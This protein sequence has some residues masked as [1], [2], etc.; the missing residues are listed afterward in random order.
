MKSEPK[1]IGE[2][3]SVKNFEKFQHYK[4]RSP[5]WIK[6]YN[7]LLDNYEFARLPDA[8]KA[9]LIAIW[10]LASRY[11]N[12]IPLDLGWLTKRINTTTHLNLPI[13]EEHGFIIIEHGLGNA[14]IMLASCKQNAPTERER[15]RETES[16]SRTALPKK[17]FEEIESALR[18]AAGLENDPSPSLLDL[19]SVLGLLDK[20]YSLDEDILPVVRRA[21]Q[22]KS[23]K[24]WTYFTNAIVEAK[25]KR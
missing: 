21:G 16:Y 19:S 25:G 2:Y 12:R 23:I 22:G 3:F 20:G 6:L 17:K 8:S 11:Q 14:S 15:E 4:H 13:L 18:K 5:P 1:D 9:H 24:S 10:L 7:D